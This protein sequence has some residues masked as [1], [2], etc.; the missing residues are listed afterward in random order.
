M[1]SSTWRRTALLVL[2]LCVVGMAAYLYRRQAAHPYWL[3][4]EAMD[5]VLSDPG[6]ARFRN[7]FML[8]QATVCGEVNARN[9]M[10]GYVGFRWFRANKLGEKWIVMIDNDK[11]PGY[12][13]DA[14]LQDRAASS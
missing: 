2:G 5:T 9:S 11:A 6:S 4:Q 12:W 10:G 8:N 1:K 7:L 3:A 14:C 13:K